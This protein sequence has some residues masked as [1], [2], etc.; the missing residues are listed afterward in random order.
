MSLSQL[1]AYTLHPGHDEHIFR[2]GRPLQQFIVD[3]YACGE[4]NCLHFLRQHQSN[5]R[6]D[7]YKGA[8]DAMYHGDTHAA[9]IGQKLILPSSFTGG[10][11][12]MTQLYQDAMRNVC[13]CGKPDI[14]LTFTC[15]TKWEEITQS[16][17]AG[18]VASDRPDLVCR[19]FQMKLKELIRDLEKGLLGQLV[20]KVWVA[21]FQKRGLPHVHMLIIVDE[22]SKDAHTRHNR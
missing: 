21:K 7:I 13:M 19:V 16:L 4:E 17:L 14:F 20:G 15:T 3:G 8:Q 10:P 6:V 18:Q 22:E 5:L 2:A 12:Q 9:Q 1:H 11:R